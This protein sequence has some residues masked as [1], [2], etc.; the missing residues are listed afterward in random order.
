[1]ELVV[2][3]FMADIY[4]DQ[5]KGR[6]SHGQ[7]QDVDKRIEFVLPQVTERDLDVVLEHKG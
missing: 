7:P 6:K 5:D 1:M 4:D 2:T 3:E